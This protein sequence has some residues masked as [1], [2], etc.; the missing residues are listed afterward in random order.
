MYNMFIIFLLFDICKLIFSLDST[1]KNFQ[2]LSVNS[3]NNVY[4]NT[5]TFCID[6][7]IAFKFDGINKIY[8]AGAEPSKLIHQNRDDCNGYFQGW[9]LMFTINHILQ[10][11][12]ITINADDGNI[13]CNFNIKIIKNKYTE[14]IFDTCYWYMS[15]AQFPII[16]VTILEFSSI[17]PSVVPSIAPSIVPSIAPSIVPSIAPSVVPSIAPSVV[18]SVASSIAPSV[19]PSVASSI[20]PSIAPSIVP[21]VTIDFD[22][23]IN[24]NNEKQFDIIG[25]KMFVIIFI[26]LLI[27]TIIV[28][29]ICCICCVVKIHMCYLENQNINTS[30]RSIEMNNHVQHIPTYTMVEKV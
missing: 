9:K 17:V 18:P 28:F 19:V 3:L 23:S 8:I 26:T 1:L 11:S 7:F 24:K 16:K 20:A 30:I 2:M 12:T 13:A 21:S 5:D 29:F 27:F 14:T 6:H 25:K 22:D 10:N 4:T 15:G